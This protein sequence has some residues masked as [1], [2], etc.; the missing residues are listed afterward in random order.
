VDENV[1]VSGVYS[2]LDQTRAGVK[3]LAK[4]GFPKAEISASSIAPVEVA[5]FSRAAAEHSINVAARMTGCLLGLGVVPFLAPMLLAA[6]VMAAVGLGAGELLD[7]P[8]RLITQAAEATA[9]TDDGVLLTINCENLNAAK[10]ATQTLEST[11]AQNLAI[12]NLATFAGSDL[13]AREYRG[14]DGEIHHHTRTYMRDHVEP[15]GASKA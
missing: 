15:Q 10:R 14:E 13:K 4:A 9:A 6:P 1:A 11:G 3:A 5:P 8:D 2:D 7:A 12:T